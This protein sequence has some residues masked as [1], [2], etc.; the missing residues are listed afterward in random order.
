M[1]KTKVKRK[2]DRRL[3]PRS[4]FSDLSQMEKEMEEMFGSGWW[5]YPE[6]FGFGWPRRRWMMEAKEFLKPLIDIYEEKDDLVIKAEVPG[7][8]KD[9]IEI[10]L[11]DNC[12]KMKGQ[13]K[14]TDEREDGGYYWSERAFGTFERSIHLP[15][16]VVAD[17]I[18]ARFCDGVLEVRLPKTEAVKR[19]EIKIDVA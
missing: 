4:P 9:D 5:R 7:M 11:I 18:S 8:M 1:E 15:R 10:K 3:M 16:E 17:K 13:K 6:R 19:K 14:R 12:L 2:E